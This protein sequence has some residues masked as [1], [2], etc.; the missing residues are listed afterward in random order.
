MDI[1]IDNYNVICIKRTSAP[2]AKK[3]TSQTPLGLQ[4]P[5][6]PSL[7]DALHPIPALCLRS[8]GMLTRG[9]ANPH[10]WPLMHVLHCD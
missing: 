6:G 7:H 10:A 2:K 1:C 8:A 5:R 9:H 3:T 4:T